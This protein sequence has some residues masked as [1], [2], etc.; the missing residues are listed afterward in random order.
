MQGHFQGKPSNGTVIEIHAS[1]TDAEESE[2]D[3][4]YQPEDLED[5]LEL[6][7]KQIS[8]YSSVGTGM[9]MQE[10]KRY[11][12]YQSTLALENKMKQGKG[13]LNSA[14]TMH[15][16]QPIPCLNNTRDEL[17]HRHHQVGNTK[18]KLI[19]LFVAKDGEAICSQKKARAGAD[20]GFAHQLLIA[21]SRLQLQ[22][23]GKTTRTARYD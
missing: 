6:N 20:C 17:T 2:S 7:Q 18:I 21:K 23:V 14:K 5:L 3:E 13:Q 9:P 19:T 1:T 4:S 11:P 10:V 16:S 15:S 8:F 12:E 22:K